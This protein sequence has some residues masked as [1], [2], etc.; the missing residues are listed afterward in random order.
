MNFP[1]FCQ[2]MLVIL[3]VTAPLS[4]ISAITPKDDSAKKPMT[5]PAPAQLQLHKKTMH[6]GAQDGWLSHERSFSNKINKFLGAQWSGVNVGTIF[7]LY[8]GDGEMTFPIRVQYSNLVLTPK[9]G[10]WNKNISQYINCI[11]QDIN[12]CP[13]QPMQGEQ[14]GDLY[15]IAEG[16]KK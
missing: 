10:R 9:A 1:S 5:C 14:Q 11:S 13:F 6:W 12:D 8:Q 16:L 3:S 4:A 15:E 2:K 7:C